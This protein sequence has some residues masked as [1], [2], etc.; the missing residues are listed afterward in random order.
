ML[1]FIGVAVAC[2]GAAATIGLVIALAYPIPL[3]TEE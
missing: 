1:P 2:I 3:D